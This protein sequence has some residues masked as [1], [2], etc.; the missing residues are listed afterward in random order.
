MPADCTVY[1]E[2]WVI[3]SLRQRCLQ[4]EHGSL[5]PSVIAFSRCTIAAV[6]TV[7]WNIP[8]Q[9]SSRT[10]HRTWTRSHH[11]GTDVMVVL[12][13]QFLHLTVCL[14]RDWIRE[15]MWTTLTL[16]GRSFELRAVHFPPIYLEREWSI[17]LVDFKPTMQ[18]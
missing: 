9:S 7:T 17:G 4:I 10:A 18:Y 3:S 11:G 15:V 6:N 16:K 2:A 14:K 12:C 8:V 13:P 1:N 5:R